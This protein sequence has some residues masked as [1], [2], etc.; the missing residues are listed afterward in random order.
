MD[1]DFGPEF[2]A[3]SSMDQTMEDLRKLMGIFP[4]LESKI[5]Q[6][7]QNQMANQHSTQLSNLQ[8]GVGDSDTMVPSIQRGWELTWGFVKNIVDNVSYAYQNG[9]IA[10][11]YAAVY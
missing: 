4:S 9:L 7:K 2:L 10:I 1:P 5:L 3:E 8:T 11:L 6:F